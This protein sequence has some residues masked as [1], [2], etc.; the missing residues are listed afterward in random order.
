MLQK[1]QVALISPNNQRQTG[2]RLDQ[3]SEKKR[4]KKLVRLKLQETHRMDF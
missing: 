4:N 3:V 1:L 2:N